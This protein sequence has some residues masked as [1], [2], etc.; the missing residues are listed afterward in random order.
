MAPLPAQP[1]SINPAQKRRVVQRKSW[2][3]GPDA[4]IR[5]SRLQPRSEVLCFQQCY[6]IAGALRRCEKSARER[7]TD[8]PAQRISCVFVCIFLPLQREMRG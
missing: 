8:A 3:P 7:K 6:L 1:Q 2:L 5:P 4:N